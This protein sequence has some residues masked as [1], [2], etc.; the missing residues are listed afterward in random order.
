MPTTPSLDAVT[1]IVPAAIAPHVLVPIDGSPFAERAVPVAA[2]YAR[3]LDATLHLVRVHVPVVGVP[4]PGDLALP[5]YDAR[6]DAEA[7]VA[8]LTYLER[9]ADVVRAETGLPVTTALREGRVVEALRDYENERHCGLVVS[10]SHGRGGFARILEGSVTDQLV[11]EG[12]APV[13]VVHPGE[14]ARPAPPARPPAHILVALDGSATAEQ[15][16]PLAAALA[17]RAGAELLLFHAVNPGTEEQS[18]DEEAARGYLTDIA[19]RL[20]AGVR[21]TTRVVTAPE[22][23]AAILDAADAWNADLVALASHGRGGLRRAI[24]GSVA[25]RVVRATPIAALVVRAEER[26][27]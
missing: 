24:L 3:L 16:L 15:T 4:V 10:A 20:P 23:A 9:L 14:D 12:R 5:V 27:A 25:D 13:I 17:L 26:A 18:L 1:A 2:V 19:Q 6:W 21:G 11:R 22:P 7:R 8:A